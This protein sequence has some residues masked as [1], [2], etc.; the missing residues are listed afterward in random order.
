MTERRKKDGSGEGPPVLFSPAGS[1]NLYVREIR[2]AGGA[3]GFPIT[4]EAD[5]HIRLNAGS[6]AGSPPAAGGCY[7][8]FDDA[9]IDRLHS[10]GDQ[11]RGKPSIPW[12]RVIGTDNETG[13]VEREPMEKARNR[14]IQAMKEQGNYGV[15]FAFL[16]D[17]EAA[18][19]L[20]NQMR[21]QAIKEQNAQNNAM[22]MSTTHPMMQ[23]PGVPLDKV[24]A[25][26]R[27]AKAKAA[28]TK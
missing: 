8:A 18:E 24:L 20:L 6:I 13:E 26:E 17:K 23:D 3:Q 9:F 21:M 19:V 2:T 11:K 1:M 12:R 28:A 5:Y 7:R 14:L 27:A 25:A 16:H 15:R 22:V 10:I 4:F